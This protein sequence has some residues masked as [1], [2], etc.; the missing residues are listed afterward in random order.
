MK[1]KSFPEKL[2]NSFPQKHNGPSLACCHVKV[3]HFIWICQV[4]NLKL[5]EQLFSYFLKLCSNQIETSTCPLQAA[6]DGHLNFCSF[7]C[8]I[9]ISRSKMYSCQSFVSQKCE[10]TIPSFPKILQPFPEIAKH[11]LMTSEH[12]RRALKITLRAEPFLFH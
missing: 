8:S 12:C 6:L 11:V 7:G 10:I 2:P 4:D 5:K 9:P 1:K 3:F